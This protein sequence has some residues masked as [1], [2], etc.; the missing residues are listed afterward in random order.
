MQAILKDRYYNVGNDSTY[1]I[2]M[3]PQAK[4]NGVKLPEVYSVDKGV[5]PNIK[6]ERQILHSPNL[7]TQTN[8][9]G[10]PT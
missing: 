8:C 3:Q 2:Q 4:A 7:T 6:P 5:D 10:K 9:Q 1:L